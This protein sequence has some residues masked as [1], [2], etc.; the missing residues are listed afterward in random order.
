MGELSSYRFGMWHG[1]QEEGPS[2]LLGSMLDRL[3]V[4]EIAYLSKRV[5]L[6]AREQQK[7]GT[8]HRELHL[9]ERLRY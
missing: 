4:D 5:E 3:E 9:E 6:P 8:R 2:T 7:L 1:S